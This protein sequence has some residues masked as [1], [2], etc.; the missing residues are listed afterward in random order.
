LG[1]PFFFGISL[2]PLVACRDIPGGQIT[3]RKSNPNTTS[4]LLHLLFYYSP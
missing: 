2:L 4:V 3:L 1:L